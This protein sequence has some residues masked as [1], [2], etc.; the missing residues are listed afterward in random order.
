MKKCLNFIAPMTF[1]LL[2]GCNTMNADFSCN[3]TAGDSCLTIEQVDEMT[4]FAND[5]TPTQKQ[6]DFKEK[7]SKTAGRIIR[8][9][10]GQYVWVAKT[11]G[12]K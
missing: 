9:H 6:T 10:N 5:E 11:Q 1:A 12:L 2:T 7:Q 4:R 8:Q 3:T